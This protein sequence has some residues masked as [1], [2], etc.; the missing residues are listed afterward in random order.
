MSTLSPLELLPTVQLG[1][2]FAPT[3]QPRPWQVRV[4]DA[5]SPLLRQA[6]PLLVP[7]NHT[8]S[9]SIATAATGDA[10]RA[11]ANAPMPSISSSSASAHAVTHLASRPLQPLRQD[12]VAFLQHL[13]ASV[14]ERTGKGSAVG[15]LVSSF[16][17]ALQAPKEVS[18][19]WLVDNGVTLR[20]IL[21]APDLRMTMTDLF[22]AGIVRTFHDLLQL[23]FRAEELT[24][25]RAAFGCTHFVQLFGGSYQMLLH[26][27]LSGG[28]S[29]ENM[30]Q[31][32]PPFTC[33]E[34]QTLGVTARDLILTD[35]GRPLDGFKIS[36]LGFLSLTP[37]DWAA[38]GLEAHHLEA[39][40][41]TPAAAKRIGWDPY[42]VARVFQMPD[43]WLATR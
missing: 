17:G 5:P 10:P 11:P 36:T 31:A 13:V 23:R 1:A 2:F 16:M 25:N 35:D 12:Q 14:R 27:E 32:N 6:A 15:T 18:L 21:T 28:F 19:R 37:Q 33:G 42:E 9:P 39:Y 7:T 3:P 43:T 22:S 20:D 38:L 8:Q 4:P 30:M 26:S 34:L 29:I 41:L 24:L 40:K